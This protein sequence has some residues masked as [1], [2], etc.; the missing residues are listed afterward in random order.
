MVPHSLIDL[1]LVIL[2]I[3][4]LDQ[5]RKYLAIIPTT[6]IFI[7]L[8]QLFIFS[9]IVC[10][11]LDLTII[12][13]NFSVVVIASKV[14]ILISLQNTFLVFIPKHSLA[15]HFDLVH[16]I[17]TLLIVSDLFELTVISVAAQFIL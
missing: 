9:Q 4:L 2:N 5:P 15:L 3:T 1:S 14:Q 16:H 17:M 12:L 11:S 6:S 7:L 10:L 13:M 8:L